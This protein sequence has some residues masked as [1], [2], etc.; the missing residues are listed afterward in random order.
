MKGIAEMQ[1]SQANLTRAQTEARDKY[2][3]QVTGDGAV[4]AIDKNDPSKTIK[5]S[6]P[7]GNPITAAGKGVQSGPKPAMVNGIP[8]GVSKSVNGKNTVVLP[9]D[10]NW[11]GQDAKIFQAASGATAASNAT[12][13]HRIALA[14]EVRAKSYAQTR[15]YA[16]ID[17]ANGQEQMVSADTIN[18]APKGAYAPASGGAKIMNQQAIFGEIDYTSNQLKQSIEE[19]GDQGFEPKARA[20]IAA[21]L[22]DTDPKTAWNQFLTSEVAGTL[23]DPQIKYVTSLVSMD[24]SAMSLRSIAGQG[25]S[26]DAMRS[27]ISSMLPSAGTPSAKY[28]RQQLKLFDGELN[29]LR[30]GVPGL[31]NQ[32]GNTGGAPKTGPKPGT[33]EGGYRF[34]GGDPA[35]PAS[36]VKVG[37]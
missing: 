35:N 26:S 13:D 33:V 31:G 34:K 19:M 10:P 2:Q 32:G 16:V 3:F 24:E 6:D 5:V 18:A 12:K 20:Q 30:R 28:A 17:S 36:W 23:T 1:N 4:I 14:S 7:A 11:T 25:T 15:E 9:G 27:R 22:R 29:A 8:I 21:V 37:G